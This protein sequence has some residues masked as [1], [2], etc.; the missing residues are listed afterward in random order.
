M[1]IPFDLSFDELQTY[2]GTN[3]K[4]NDFNQYWQNAINEVNC[5]DS[6]IEIRESSF[7][8]SIAN[9]YH[10]YFTSTKNA[11]IHAKMLVPKNCKNSPA[12][13]KF[14]GLN[15]NCGQF[16]DHLHFV[17]EGYSVFSLDCRGQAG[18]SQD[19]F[20]TSNNTTSSLL[21][22]GLN[23]ALEGDFTNL[24]YR[25]VLLDTYKLYS[26][27][28]NFDF[29]DSSRIAATGWSQGGALCIALAYLSSNIKCIAPVHPYLS[30]YKRV[31]QMQ[32]D[33]NAYSGIKQFF[34]ERDP[35]H[36]KEDEVFHALGYID[37]KNM[38]EKINS[39]VFFSL[40]L[41][42][43]TCPPSSQYAIYN[44]LNCKKTINIFYDFDHENLVNLNDEI[45][46]FIR[47]NI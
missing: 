16:S 33:N 26:I 31:W 25:D 10:L 17:S 1:Q 24:Y 40:G 9:C 30:D 18:L 34:R 47:N 8:S 19:S 13:L 22:R 35:H 11:R 45:F 6:N 7:K 42:D 28:C 37:V 12:I 36:I 14:H 27:V 44:R 39:N 2:L 4:P 3:E 29:I 15:C 43:K 46:T 20:L 32:L 23:E 41:L 38:A 21:I 5:I